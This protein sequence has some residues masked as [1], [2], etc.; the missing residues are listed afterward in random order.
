MASSLMIVV[1]ESYIVIHKLCLFVCLKSSHWELREQSP[2]NCPDAIGRKSDSS[3][4]N[5]QNSCFFYRFSNYLTTFPIGYRLEILN[6]GKFGN[7]W[8]MANWPIIP[9]K[10]QNWHKRRTC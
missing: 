3:G 7:M 8:G 6:Q 4:K 1:E 5:D 10:G 2:S 9:K